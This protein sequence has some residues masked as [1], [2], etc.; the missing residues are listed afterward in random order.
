MECDSEKWIIRMSMPRPNS[1]VLWC[2]NCIHFSDHIDVA[3]CDDCIDKSE[4]EL[5][6]E[7]EGQ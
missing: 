7:E 3:P 1:N 5:S 6:V 2:G 4:W